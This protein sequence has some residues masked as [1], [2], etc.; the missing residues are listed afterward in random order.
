MTATLGMIFVPTLQIVSLE[1][2][3]VIPGRL[4]L[5]SARAKTKSWVAETQGGEA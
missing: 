3:E 1:L 5:I 2:R 4:Q